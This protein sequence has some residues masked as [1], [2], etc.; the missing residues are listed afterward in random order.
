MKNTH[1]RGTTLVEVVVS[2]ILLVSIIGLVTM[3]LAAV[4]EGYAITQQRGALDQDGQFILARM[5]YV[6]SQQDSNTI[7]AQTKTTEF[8]STGSQLNNIEGGLFEEEGIYLTDTSLPGEYTSPTISLSNPSLATYFVASVKRPPGTSIKYRIAITDPIS[9]SCENANYEF[10]GEDK[11]PS[12]YFDTDY[13]LIP[14]DN[15][16]T[17]FENPGSCIKYKAFLEGSSGQTPVVYSSL[18]RR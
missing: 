9:G 4:F 8:I 6:A 15:N 10:V 7:Y 14:E 12:S 2:S 11:T 16:N 13:F 1:K 3:S 18:I 5:K 17:G